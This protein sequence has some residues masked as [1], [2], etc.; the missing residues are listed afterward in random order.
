MSFIRNGL[1]SI[2]NPVIPLDSKPSDIEIAQLQFQNI[3][4]LLE[5]LGDILFNT[6]IRQRTPCDPANSWM[7][8]N[9]KHLEA[10][11]TAKVISSND[12][13]IVAKRILTESAAESTKTLNQMS[14]E[15]LQIV[16]RC[17][18][19]FNRSVSDNS[20]PHIAEYKRRKYGGIGS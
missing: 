10:L 4:D 8:L 14:V 19:R 2:G 12:D 1:T 11:V 17:M 13:I 18:H 7:L 5:V 20:D 3:E 9:D 16:K 15:I 6:L